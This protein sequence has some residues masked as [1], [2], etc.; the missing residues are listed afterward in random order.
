MLAVACPYVLPDDQAF[1]PIGVLDL[2]YASRME[3]VEAALAGLGLRL[4]MHVACAVRLLALV[5][6]WGGHEASR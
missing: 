3:D 2:R 4:I 1:A 5:G 6:G